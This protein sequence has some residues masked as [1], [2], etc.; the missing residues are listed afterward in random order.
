MIREW[1]ALGALLMAL[2]AVMIVLLA[3]MI[4]PVRGQSLGLHSYADNGV[5]P[6]QR[7]HKRVIAQYPMYQTLVACVPRLVCGPERCEHSGHVAC[8]QPAIP[9]DVEICLTDEELARAK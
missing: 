8:N 1:G 5:C 6:P 9:V 7:P 2:F 3:M 4:G